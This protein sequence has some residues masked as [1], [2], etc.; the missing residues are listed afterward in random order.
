MRSQRRAGPPSVR[1]LRPEVHV[2]MGDDLLP[3]G[4][5]RDEVLEASGGCEL[6][7]LVGVSLKCPETFD[8]IYDLSAKVHERYGAVVYVDPQPIKGRNTSHCIDFH[9]KIDIED[10]SAQT[11]AEMDR[12]KKAANDVEKRLT[13][14][15]ESR[16]RW[17]EVSASHDASA[18]TLSL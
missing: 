15:S 1:F 3:L 7:L 12:C 4:N 10:F 5:L 11:L 6:L 17:Y 13:R 2:Q 18:A 8:L 14:Q 16:D 9:L